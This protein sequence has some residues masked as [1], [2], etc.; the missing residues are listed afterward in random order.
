MSAVSILYD[1][2]LRGRT[3]RSGTVNPEHDRAGIAGA[4]CDIATRK[5]VIL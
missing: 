3:G 1:A 5:E 4:G 2:F